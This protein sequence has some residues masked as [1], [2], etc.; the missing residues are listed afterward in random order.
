MI[1]LRIPSSHP[2]APVIQRWATD[3]ESILNNHTQDLKKIKGL[4]Q[5]ILSNNPALGKSN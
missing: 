2:N 3:K 5:T 4:L 1:P